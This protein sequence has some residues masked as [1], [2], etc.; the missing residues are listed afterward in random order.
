MSTAILAA[1]Q[2]LVSPD[3][4]LPTAHPWRRGAGLA[5]VV[6]GLAS[7]ALAGVGN[8]IAW[9][10]ASPLAVTAL[11]ATLFTAAATG[12]GALPVL[13]ARNI[14]ARAQDA[15]LGFGAGVMLAATAFSLVVPGIEAGEALTGNR[16]GAAGIVAVGIVLGGITMLAL[17]RLLPHE[18]FV[19]G[20]SGSPRQYLKRIWLFV[21]AIAIH[22]LPEGL[23]VGVGFGTE[24]FTSGAALALGI[25]IQ[26]IPE[27]LVVALALVA[28]GYSRGFAAA[29]ALASGLLEP[30][31]GLLGAGV[32]SLSQLMLPVGLAFSAGAMLFVVS[33]E[34]IPESHRKGHEREATLG[35]LGGFVVMML[36][37]TTL[38]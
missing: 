35:L 29:V 31:G 5:I 7:L 23:A 25:G 2:W 22:N 20:V 12:V 3:S 24:S 38:G 14:S 34:I 33:H 37:D 9:L 10:Q 32:L 21:L 26:N 19:S 36:L 28:T 27:G 17:D 11:V 15:M 30:V 4:T 13:M 6:V 16:F 18:H 8:L 1:R